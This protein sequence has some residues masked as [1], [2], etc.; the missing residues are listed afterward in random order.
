[1]SR[2]L[3]LLFAYSIILSCTNTEQQ[4]KTTESK[5]SSTALS[6]NKDINNQ[7]SSD[8]FIVDKDSITILPFEI[9]VSLSPKAIERIKGKET[10]M[11]SVDF[12][13]IPKDSSKANISEDGIFYVATDTKE[14]QYGQVARF[15]NIKFPR[16][17]Y[18]NLLDKDI[19]LGVN[20]YSGRKSSPDNLLN[21][22]PL[23]EK[24]SK[25]VNQKFTVDGKLI[26]G[27]D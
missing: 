16:D 2:I 26:Y 20:I 7:T 24:I 22:S 3:L 23:F 1:M 11:V 13:G 19:E 5:D 4:V 21:C 10:I 9:E 14:I 15:E 18:D 8:Y 6:Q 25:V 17:I 12:T 27:D